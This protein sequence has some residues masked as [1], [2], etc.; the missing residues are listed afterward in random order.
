MVL[1][2]SKVGGDSLAEAI[3]SF[4]GCGRIEGLRLDPMDMN[5]REKKAKQMVLGVCRT[6]VQRMD[7][8]YPG[9]RSNSP[10]LALLAYFTPPL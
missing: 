4:Q 9:A 6:P 2:F 1:Y 5:G 7:A 10:G 8:T 3:M